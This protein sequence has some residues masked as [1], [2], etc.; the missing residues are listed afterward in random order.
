M[1]M[2]AV[3]KAHNEEYIYG[4]GSTRIE[5]MAAFQVMSGTMLLVSQ[6][7]NLI[8]GYSIWVDGNDYCL[9]RIYPE[10]E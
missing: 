9:T 1:E 6:V 5:A 4:M 2:W 8:R 10:S 7:R 3:V